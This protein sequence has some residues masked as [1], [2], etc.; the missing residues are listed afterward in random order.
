MVPSLHIFLRKIAYLKLK[1]I[2]EKKKIKMD[3]GNRKLKGKQIN[4]T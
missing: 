4:G 1:K 2:T 3:F